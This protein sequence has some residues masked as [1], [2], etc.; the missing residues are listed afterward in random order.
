M[1]I[2]RPSNDFEGSEMAATV[3]TV[4]TSY[5]REDVKKMIFSKT[6]NTNGAYLFFLPGYKTD[7][8]GR[9]IWYKAFEIRDNF[10]DKFKEKYY[11]PDRLE[12]PA[13]YFA[14]QY[15]MLY[16]NGKVD[17][18][19]V[20]V[21]GRNFKKYPNF[22]RITKRC[23]F[24][25]AYAADMSQGVFVLDLPLANG[26]IQLTEWS[27]QTDFHGR[28]RPNI[29]DPDGALPVF[30]QL[31][32]SGANPWV[33]N[34]DMSQS[35][36]LSEALADSSRLYNLDDILLQK[37]KEE[38]ISKLRNMYPGQV[39]D[40]CMAGFPGLTQ[41]RGVGFSPAPKAQEAPNQAHRPPQ[42]FTPPQQATAQAKAFVQPT[43]TPMASV[44]INTNFENDD[45]PFIDPSE[46]PPNPMARR[47]SWSTAD[48]EAFLNENK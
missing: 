21:N 42:A 36:P 15:I 33:I 48:A 32:D 39:F 28:T 12:D 46:L 8:L 11:V 25:V 47:S 34:V 31:R 40:D 4:P 23:I 7:S 3:S 41:V 16:N 38:I 5:I 22:G 13:S 35:V 29:N 26:G 14:K 45:A 6:V 24:N 19:V 27:K 18:E 2:I 20:N 9:G 43:Q 17:L 30:L 1:A 10:G 44:P 37:P